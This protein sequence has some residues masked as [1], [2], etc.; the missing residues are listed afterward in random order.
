MAR[1][2]FPSAVEA[3]APTAVTINGLLVAAVELQK[4]PS[5]YQP[6]RGLWLFRSP[7]GWTL[8]TLARQERWLDDGGVDIDG[9]SARAVVDSFANVDDLAKAIRSRY[10]DLG[11]TELLDAAAPDDTEMHRVWAPVAFERD[12]LRAT[13]YRPDLVGQGTLSS[14]VLDLLADELIVHLEDAG[15]GVAD[16]EM[17]RRANPWT[18]PPRRGLPPPLRV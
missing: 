9:C 10:G 18:E 16:I 3:H 4:F 11:C 14:A 6:F 5:D 15:F 1:P 7:T 17:A 8:L 12:L 13:F 2:S